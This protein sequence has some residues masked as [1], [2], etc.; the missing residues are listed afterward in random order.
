MVSAT[1]SVPRTQSTMLRVASSRAMKY[2]STL[3]S[4]HQQSRRG[5]GGGSGEGGEGAGDAS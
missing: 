3:R 5:Q 4:G 2:G 1:D